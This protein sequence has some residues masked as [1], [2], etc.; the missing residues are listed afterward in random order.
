MSQPLASAATA[1]A[2][3]ADADTKA[4]P[5]PEDILER[6]RKE[7][8]RAKEAEEDN[9]TEFL[10][11]LRFARLD[12]HWPEQILNQ[13][14]LEG[15]PALTIPKLPAFI[16]Q[17]V[18]DARQNKPAVKVHPVDSEA[19]VET[20]EIF[21]GLIRHIEYSSNADVAYDTGVENAVGGG[22]GY[23]RIGIRHAFDDSFELDVTIDRVADPLTVY[24]DPDSTAADSSDWNTAFVVEKVR[25]EA[26]KDNWP[27]AEKVDWDHDFRGAEGWLDGDYVLVAEWWTRERYEKTIVKLSDGTTVEAARL[28]DPDFLA[29][30][31]SKNVTPAID[32]S[33]GQPVPPRQVP[34]HRVRQRILT[35]AEVLEERVWPGKYIPIVPVYGE[36]VNVEGKRYL[37]S[38]IRGAKDAQR[39]YNYWVTT[40]TEL[41]ALAPRVPFIGP[42]GAFVT[43]ADKWATVN[44]ESHPFVEYDG[45]VAPAR[46]PLDT[47]G[48]ASSMQQALVASDDMKAIMGMYDASLGQ[49]SNETSGRAIL[50]RQREGDVSTFHFIDNLSRAIRHTGRI[51]IDLIPHVYNEARVVRVI[52]EDGSQE[53]VKINQPVPVEDQNGQPQMRM[54]ANGQPLVDPQGQPI[55][56]TRVYDITAGKYDL[57]VSTGP[58][59]TTR[60]EE[61]AASMTELVRAFPQAAP[62]VADL[63]AK[64]SDWPEADTVAERFKTLLPPGAEEGDGI[65]PQV[66]QMVEEGMKRIQALEAENEQLKGEKLIEAEK[67]RLEG[68]K[69][70]VEKQKAETAAFEAQTDRMEALA[71][72]G[73]N[74]MTGQP[75]PMPMQ[76]APQ[77]LRAV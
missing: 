24:G 4:E 9:R 6:A 58:S 71:K 56:M 66:K 12:E 72:L 76:P 62:L 60:R 64:N 48:G 49:R 1:S 73:I 44:R 47:G 67:L 57:T 41:I 51:L 39:R 40:A 2:E 69:I 5:A 8:D 70:G 32:R 63:I 3:A 65:P 59:F 16:R 22:F 74:P 38:L 17:V 10:D 42:K 35:G 27:K 68:E 28:E 75:M 45:Q 23:W 20:A 25:K 11:D 46:Q 77:P 14:R 19:D 53:P 55:P 21:N 61:A 54:G 7:F 33:T 29:V 13:R 34:C 18:N 36:E 37:R 31:A 30:L 15:R 50:A 52:G 43:D 26:F